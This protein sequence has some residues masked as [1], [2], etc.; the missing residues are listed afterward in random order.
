MSSVWPP[1]AAPRRPEGSGTAPAAPVLWRL[2]VGYNSAAMLPWQAKAS[3][4][5]PTLLVD[6]ASTDDTARVAGRL[7]YRVVRLDRNHGFGRGVMAGLRTLGSGLAL[8]IN[9]DAAID[10]R[11]VGALVAAADR[12]PDCDLFMPRLTDSRGRDFFRHESAIEPRVRDRVPP[13]GTACVPMIS[14]AVMLVRVDRFL[15]AGGFDP[16]IFLFFEDD[17]LAL[18]YR[19]A[20]RPIIYVPAAT[21]THLGSRSSH[22]DREAER[23]KNLSHGWSAAY[24]MR[25]HRRRWRG[26]WFAGMLAKLSVYLLGGRWQRVGRQWARIRGFALALAGRPAPYLP[27]HEP[28]VERLPETV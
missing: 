28:R 11:G 27:R 22:G 20:Q 23:V 18:R 1:T 5:L 8:V 17:D 25:K 15:A 14:G 2:M 26:L 6:N 19:A 7:G 16:S 24:L 4:P 3:A 10:A 13:T 9:P 21:A 12:Y